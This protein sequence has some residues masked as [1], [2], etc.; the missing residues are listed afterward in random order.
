[1]IDESTIEAV[2]EATRRSFDMTAYTL[3]ESKPWGLSF[4]FWREQRWEEVRQSMGIDEATFALPGI[5]SA[6]AESYRQ[7]CIT[8]AQRATRHFR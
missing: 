3:S 6:F 5:R 1:M 4:L 7:A 2:A 8:Q